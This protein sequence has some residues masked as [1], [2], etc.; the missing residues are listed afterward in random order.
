MLII[1][2]KCPACNEDIKMS[3]CPEHVPKQALSRAIELLEVIEEQN[4]CV[5][6]SC[7]IDFDD[8]DL[9]KEIEKLKEML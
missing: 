3:G 4:N 5:N 1:H 7:V 8:I 9:T 2:G 6:V